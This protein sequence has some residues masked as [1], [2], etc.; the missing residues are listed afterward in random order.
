[1]PDPL[2]IGTRGSELALWQARHVELLLNEAR[3]DLATEIVIV[4]TRGDHDRDT[5]LDRLGG[6][7]VFVSRLEEELLAGRIEIAVHSAKDLPSELTG[8]LTIAAVPRRGVV[9]DALVCRDAIAFDD[10]RDRATVGTSSPRRAASI[11]RLRPDV[12][13]VPIRGNVETRIGR[14]DR[15]EVDATVLAWAGMRRLGL[16]WRIDHVFSVRDILPAP[17]QGAIA[18][19]TRADDTRTIQFA[20]SIRD[21]GTFHCVLAERALLASLDAGC[22]ASLGAIATWYGSE[23]M[24]MTARVLSEDGDE[25][26]EAGGTVEQQ[27]DPDRLAGIVARKLIRDGAE[28]LMV[29]PET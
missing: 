14:V 15:G 9:N 18:V 12:D 22:H 7:G 23:G 16:A 17:A 6:A 3:P 26:V 4:R 5:P 28:R 2:R 1:M 10:L 21:P 24:S 27:A 20:E 13:T 25:I 19:Q 8:G 11:R 29:S